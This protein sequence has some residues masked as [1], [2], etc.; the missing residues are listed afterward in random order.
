MTAVGEG[1]QGQLPRIGVPVAEGSGSVGCTPEPAQDGG[2]LLWG[3]SQPRPSPRCPILS[4]PATLQS[5]CLGGRTEGR[6][7]CP[8]PRRHLEDGLGRQDR[9]ATAGALL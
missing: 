7:P 8:V 9:E 6:C 5:P 4:S 3:S 2:R 1:P